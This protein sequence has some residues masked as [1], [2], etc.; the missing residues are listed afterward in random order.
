MLPRT[1]RCGSR[2]RRR[3]ETNTLQRPVSRPGAQQVLSRAG[4]ARGRPHGQRTLRGVPG[5]DWCSGRSIVLRLT[6]GL[7]SL[8]WESRWLLPGA[9]RSRP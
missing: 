9:R 1:A 4:E 8:P 2:V 3:S 5:V 7:L 6:D